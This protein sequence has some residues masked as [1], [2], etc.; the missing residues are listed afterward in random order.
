M[1]YL[2]AAFVL[3]VAAGWFLALISEVV[4]L[5]IISFL[6][7][8]IVDPVITAIQDALRIGRLSAIGIFFVICLFIVGLGL[9]YLMPIIGHQFNSAYLLLKSDEVRAAFTDRARELVEQNVSFIPAQDLHDQISSYTHAVISDAASFLLNLVSVFSLLIIMPFIL[10]FLLKDGT[11]MKKG[12]I[13]KVPNRFFEMSL[14]L[15][16]TID[17]H[18]GAYIRGQMLVAGAVGSLSMVALWILGVPYFFVIGMLA[19]LANLIPYL[20]PIA[21]TIPAMTVSILLFEDLS[22]VWVAGYGGLW[23]PLVAVGIAF[24]LIQLIDNILISPLIVS[25][26]ADL[27]PLTVIVTIVI[28]GR[29]FGLVGMLL[30]VPAVSI[31]KVVVRDIIW[32]F[33]HYRLL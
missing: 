11:R 19:G 21:G 10:F 9:F 26:T 14:N 32:H 16:D 3:L 6:M 8:Y 4:I 2:I 5:F 22:P 23:E 33:K 18:L 1:I 15:I 24:A 7:F 29:L 25:K 20:G 13:S 17:R 27:H 30:G 31:V 28:G 12:L